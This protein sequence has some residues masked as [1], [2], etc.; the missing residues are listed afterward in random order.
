[1]QSCVQQRV[2]I[3]M[4]NI[5]L[6][7]LQTQKKRNVTMIPPPGRLERYRPGAVRLVGAHTR[8]DLQHFLLDAIEQRLD[9]ALSLL[10][11]LFHFGIFGLVIYLIKLP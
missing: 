4:V 1:M 6:E 7:G 9:R 3:K 11:A 10:V 8:E 5:I 2:S